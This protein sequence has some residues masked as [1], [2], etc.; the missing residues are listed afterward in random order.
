MSDVIITLETLP[1]A[2][3]AFNMGAPV[4]M[5]A[6]ASWLRL[7]SGKAAPPRVWQSAGVALARINWGRWIADCP[8][9]SGAMVVSRKDP[10]FWCPECGQSGWRQVEFPENADEIEE[11][12]VKRP[13]KR[14]RNW[15]P[16]ETV[17]QLE[18]E[19]SGHGIGV[20]R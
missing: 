12:L 1:E 5:W 2:E 20:I 7:L 18:A 6:W 4:S 3:K 14:V 19:N 10:W 16:G 15:F 17:A 8:V 11:I 13:D 9:C